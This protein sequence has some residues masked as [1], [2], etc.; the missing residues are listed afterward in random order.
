VGK[1]IIVLE[2]AQRAHQE[3]SVS[4]QL[5]DQAMELIDRISYALYGAASANLTP[6][7]QAPFPTST[8]HFRISLGVEDG[9]P[10]FSDPEV[11]GLSE[12]GNQIYWGQNLGA[13]NERVVVWAN[14]VAE[15]LQDEVFNGVDDNNNG[16]LDELGLS[17]TMDR[18]SVTVLLTL[19]RVQDD[20]RRTQVSKST[21]VTCRN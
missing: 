16:L 4:L 13:G 14:S 18:K 11:I 17:F 1:L 9:E 10:V 8:I 15:M 21:M 19:E 6:I 12:D 20:G 7:S 2:Q 5:E 3:E